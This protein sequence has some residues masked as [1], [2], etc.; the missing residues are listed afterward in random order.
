KVDFYED[1]AFALHQAIK[2]YL[3]SMVQM[4]TKRPVPLIEA[5]SIK[6]ANRVM[7]RLDKMVNSWPPARPGKPL[8]T[9]GLRLEY[10]ELLQL[11]AILA[12][13]KLYEAAP[14]Q[15]VPLRQACGKLNQKAL[16]LSPL[17]AL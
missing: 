13:G 1:E 7:A 16:N 5:L 15:A 9:R 10:D 6:P 4:S 3:F 12:A 8:K 14:T 17:F 2:Y 11:N